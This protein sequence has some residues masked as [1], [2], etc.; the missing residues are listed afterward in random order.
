MVK[1]HKKKKSVN[2]FRQPKTTPLEKKQRYPILTAK[3][4][5]Y[6]FSV[7]TFLTALIILLSFFGAAGLAGRKIFQGLYALFGKAS[8]LLPFFLA[9]AG[10]IILYP[11]KKRIYAPINLGIT[12]TLLG[13]CGIFATQSFR[14]IAELPGSFWQA[15]F[16]GGWLGYL[17]AYPLFYYFGSWVSFIIF[18]TLALIGFLIL[19]E[20]FPKSLIFE[21][22]SQPK[23][24]PQNQTSE[25]QIKEEIRKPISGLKIK[26]GFKAEK[27]SKKLASKNFTL[28]EIK[29]TSLR[30]S[31]TINQQYKSPPIEFLDKD[32]E[33]SSAGDIK[34][35][36]FRIQKTL[37]NF[38]I[39]VEIKGV[40]VGPTVTQ[41]TFKPAEGVK[42]SRIVGLVNNLSLALASH[43]L[44]IEAPIPGQSLVGIEVPNEKRALVHLRS[45]IGSPKFQQNPSPLL[46]A[47]GRDVAG[48]PI[49]ANLEE[50]PHLLVAGSTGSGKTICLQSLILS[51]IYRNSPQILK[52][53][54]VDP[55]RVEFPVYDSIAHLLAPVIFTP[56]RTV[57]ALNWLIGE[58]ERRFEV[59]SS[60]KARDIASFNEMLGHNSKLREKGLEFMP[61]ILLIIDELAD[62]MAAKGREVEAGV[63]RLAQMSRAVGIH[64]ILATQRPSVEVITGLIKANITSRIAFQVA[65]QVDSRTIL[66]MSG[67]ESLLGK[68]DMLFLTASLIKPK[69]I[70]GSYVTMREIK[71]VVNFLQQEPAEF[72][73]ERDSLK[74]S[75]EEEL[76]K[77]AQSSQRGFVEED[78]LYETAKQLVI[79]S[80]KAS[81]SLL[82]RRLRIGYARAARILDMLEQKGVVGPTE[83]AKPR[84]VYLSQKASDDDNFQSKDDD[85]F[86]KV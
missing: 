26:S 32:Q 16:S 31:K 39:S 55:K 84:K 37:E 20:F 70:Q 76:K 4:R 86:Q 54:L 65:S 40:N 68:G 75:L 74:Q 79:E 53:I 9:I 43:P 56:Q 7:L 46:L 81:A 30:F 38:G 8:F 33:K 45:L 42:L 24:I 21:R 64:L 62:L 50:M 19:W 59:L 29:T 85:G 22:F 14:N 12:L 13:F 36:S 82:Q 11:S 51:L 49:Y 3:L 52:L 77:P 6:I 78:S 35:R 63:A 66:D 58:M 15:N 48:E 28:P 69:R 83:G 34:E 2:K 57:N 23:K 60:V 27:N 71:K 72:S 44:R 61:Y 17:L 73:Q 1:R 47:L 10:L 80:Q 18:T 25:N 67:A 41:Y 5:R